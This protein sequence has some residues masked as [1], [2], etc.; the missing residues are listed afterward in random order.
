MKFQIFTLLDF[1]PEFHNEKTF[2]QQSADVMVEAEQNGFEGIWIGEEHFYTFGLCPNPHMFLAGLAGRTSTLTLGTATALPSLGHPLMRAVDYGMLDNISNG[3]LRFGIGRGG[4]PVH[5]PPFQIDATEAEARYFEALEIIRKAWYS[6]SF[7]H[8]GKFWQIPEISLA[9]KPLQNPVPIYQATMSEGGYARAA[10]AGDGVYLTL[11]PGKNE[12]VC[13]LLAKYRQ[14]LRE[15]GKAATAPQPMCNLHLYID[16]DRDVAE[17]EAQVH[18]DRYASH[19]LTM[20]FPGVDTH[21][22][23]MKEGISRFLPKRDEALVGNPEDVIK[24]IYEVRELFG[25][26]NLGINIQAGG[27]DF[28]RVHEQL[29]LFAKEVMPEFNNIPSADPLKQTVA[30]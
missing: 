9:P 10:E 4:I 21:T 22:A 7:S 15:N 17:A 20:G 25:L 2:L 8:D 28:K 27:R 30:A 14:T 12:F 26:D 3:R 24:K 19:I 13:D 29:K 23:K 5:F 11:V 18:M 1:I 16:K 6:K